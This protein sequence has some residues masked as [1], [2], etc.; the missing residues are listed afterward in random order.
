MM[1]ACARVRALVCACVF[2]CALFFLRAAPSSHH[3]RLCAT[4][5][6]HATDTHIKKQKATRASVEAANRWLDNLHSLKGWARAKFEGR[7]AELDAFFE[8]E[9]FSDALDYLTA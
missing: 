6:Q 9:G 2:A 1:R 8:N 3:H 4:P 7:G 5:T